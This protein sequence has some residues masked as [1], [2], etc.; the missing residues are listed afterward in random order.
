MQATPEGQLTN[1]SDNRIY[2]YLFWD[3]SYSFGES[4]YNYKSGF[5]VKSENTIEFLQTKLSYIG[6]NNKEI[7][8]FIVFWLPELSKN[9]ENFIYFR[10]NDNI[11]NSS[12]LDISPKP[13]SEIRLFMEFEKY[14]NQQKLPEQI[15]PKL[16]RKGFTVL[17]WGGAEINTPIFE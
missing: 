2:E 12:V 16:T 8:D 14:R 5:Y 17:E 7:N 3:G 1:K 11:D 6:L 4:H 15:L 13:D 9:D 10:I